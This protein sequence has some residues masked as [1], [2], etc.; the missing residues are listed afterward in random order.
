MNQSLLLFCSPCISVSD[1]FN[2]FHWAILSLRFDQLLLA[3]NPRGDF[4][5]DA[6]EGWC[7]DNGDTVEDWQHVSPCLH[8]KPVGAWHSGS[9]S[10]ASHYPSQQWPGW[11]CGWHKKKKIISCCFIGYF[12]HD[13]WISP[14]GIF[15]PIQRQAVSWRKEIISQTSRSCNIMAIGTRHQVLKGFLWDWYWPL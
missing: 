8:T 9:P 11:E 2:D 14:F 5:T 10:L 13:T 4:V 7:D 15:N 3:S 1:R 6:K 12:K